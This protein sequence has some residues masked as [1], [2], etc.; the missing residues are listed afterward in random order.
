MDEVSP[1]SESLQEVFRGGNLLYCDMKEAFYVPESVQ[2]F[3]SLSSPSQA[4]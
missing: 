3:H 4:R 1:P 2:Q